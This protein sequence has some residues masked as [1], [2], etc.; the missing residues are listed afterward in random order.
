V[1]PYGRLIEFAWGHEGG[2]PSHLKIRITSLRKKLGLPITGEIGIRAIV[3]TGY[4]LHGC[5][6]EPGAV[7]P[8]VT[9]TP[10]YRASRS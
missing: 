7:G 10:A 2:S 6:R 9:K 4:I 1:V 3:G 8:T 5:S